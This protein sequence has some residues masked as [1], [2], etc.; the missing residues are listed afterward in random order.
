MLKIVALYIRIS[1]EDEFLL[2]RAES[3]S[4]SNQKNMLT[5][6]VENNT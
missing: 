6:Y 1:K 3:E 4:V 5:E 2:E